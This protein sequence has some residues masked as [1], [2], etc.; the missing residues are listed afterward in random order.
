M[1]AAL[2]YLAGHPASGGRPAS[3][4]GNASG[5]RAAMLGMS[6]GG[7]IAYYAATQI[8]LAALAVF[9]PGWLTGDD[10]ALSRPEPTLAVTPQLAA[11][12]T[13]VLVLLGEDDHLFTAEQREQIAAQ[14][15]QAG[16][17]HELVIY[18]GTPHGFCCHERD[19]YRPDAAAD[20]WDRVMRLLAA[21][22]SPG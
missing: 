6:A 17:R 7:H 4:G 1:Q 15:I 14:L 12:G 22:L 8:P 13:A 5:G 11:L 3:G 10:I 16:V 20:A 19:T 18:L 2:D 9:Y 21:E